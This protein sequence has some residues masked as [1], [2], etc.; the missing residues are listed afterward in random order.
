M[1][2]RKA[3]LLIAKP[4]QC[5]RISN[6]LVIYY[7]YLVLGGVP[8]S[9]LRCLAE[10]KRGA[11]PLEESRSNNTMK[12]ITVTVEI[13]VPDNATDNDIADFV[14]VEYGECGKMALDN[15]CRT[16]GTEILDARWEHGPDYA[17]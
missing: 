2:N 8:L 14:D 6:R 1:K 16:D 12:T 3:R 13:D 7:R 5:I 9:F 11:K 4:G 10:Q 15:P 17:R